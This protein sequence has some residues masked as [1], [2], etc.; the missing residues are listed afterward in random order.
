MEEF[1]A[2]EREATALRAA[3]RKLGDSSAIEETNNL[4]IEWVKVCSR[5]KSFIGLVPQPLILFNLL[6]LVQ[7]EGDLQSTD[8]SL[9]LSSPVEEI[10]IKAVGA[11]ATFRG[12]EIAQ[13]TLSLNG[14]SAV[15][16]VAVF[17]QNLVKSTEIAA[18]S[19]TK[20]VSI[21]M[22]SGAKV[23]LKTTFVPSND[24]L[25]RLLYDQLNE[26]TQRKASAREA[27]RSKAESSTSQ[28]S[29]AKKSVAFGSSSSAS[30]SGGPPSK[31][32]RWFHAAIAIVP[33]VKNYIF[34]AAFVI[35]T[36]YRGHL[37]ALPEPV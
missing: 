10:T 16:D 6:F 23:Y 18:R 35:A 15:Q 8:L 36:N 12:V 1:Q 27:L 13:A 5:N 34:F 32:L 19:Y 29:K 4:T 17:T 30:K 31:I 20:E 11:S 14:Q 37:L 21:D 2:A 7:T 22:E 26:A 24:D 28:K 33:R 25:R 9:Q 3:I